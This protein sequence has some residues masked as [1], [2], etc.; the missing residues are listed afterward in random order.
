MPSCDV[1]QLFST[2]GI[3]RCDPG[4]TLTLERG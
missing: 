2:F 1:Q 3:S 4:E